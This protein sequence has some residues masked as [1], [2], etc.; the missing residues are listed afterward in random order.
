MIV[1]NICEVND[2]EF[3]FL[4]V[5]SLYDASTHFSRQIYTTARFKHDGT[6]TLQQGCQVGYICSGLIFSL[7][8]VKGLTYCVNYI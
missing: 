6:A 4:G 5:I 3:F 1:N 2:E 8:R 7:Y